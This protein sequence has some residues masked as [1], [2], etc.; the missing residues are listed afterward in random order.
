MYNEWNIICIM[1]ILA[2]YAILNGLFMLHIALLNYKTTTSRYK[3]KA[4]IKYF[5]TIYKMLN[6]LEWE[7]INISA[8]K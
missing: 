1:F 3:T 5:H 8:F 2:F 7:Q 6:I 4:L